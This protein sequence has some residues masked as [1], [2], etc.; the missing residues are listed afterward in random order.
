VVIRVTWGGVYVVL[1]T[2]VVIMVDVL[3]L[4]GPRVGIHTSCTEHNPVSEHRNSPGNAGLSERV[5]KQR[6][7]SVL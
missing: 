6:Q 1:V 2:V 7:E 3:L 5:G 4:A